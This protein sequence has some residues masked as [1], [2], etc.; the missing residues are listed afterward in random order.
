MH[1][2]CPNMDMQFC[3]FAIFAFAVQYHAVK[4]V[5]G[6]I[7]KMYAQP[8]SIAGY[9]LPSKWGIFHTDMELRQDIIIFHIYETRTCANYSQVFRFSPLY[10]IW[11]DTPSNSH[12]S[13]HCLSFV[14]CLNPDTPLYSLVP[15]CCTHVGKLI[16]IGTMVDEDAGST[17][18]GIYIQGRGWLSI[19]AIL[20][21]WWDIGGMNSEMG[22]IQPNYVI[23]W[24]DLVHKTLIL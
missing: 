2:L 23:K 1:S 4:K 22:G 19:F 6:S 16:L 21:F 8:V 9:A 15:W 17:K 24:K 7:K 5:K 3:I 18:S 10:F 11:Y 14:A 13:L 12:P 20:F